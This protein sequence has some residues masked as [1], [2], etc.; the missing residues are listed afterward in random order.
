MIQDVEDE[1]AVVQNLED[2]DDVAK[3]LEE[4]FLMIELAHHAADE[5]NVVDDAPV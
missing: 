4:G 2:K 3:L 5:D 1:M